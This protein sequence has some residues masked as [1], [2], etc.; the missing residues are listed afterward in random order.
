MEMSNGS[1]EVRS[2]VRAPAS[3]LLA[4]T[5][6]PHV[7]HH[8]ALRR[9]VIACVALTG[10]LG[11]VVPIEADCDGD[12]GPEVVR[13]VELKLRSSDAQEIL[14]GL[15][16]LRGV[17]PVPETVIAR[18]AELL[19]ANSA[20]DTVNSRAICGHVVRIFEA[21]GSLPEESRAQIEQALLNCLSIKRCVVLESAVRVL[22]SLSKRDD[23]LVS[24]IAV[25][26]DDT[27]ELGGRV[28]ALRATGYYYPTSRT[29][30]DCITTA[31]KD[32]DPLIRWTAA[33]VISDRPRPRREDATK[34]LS[35]LLLVAKEDSDESVRA[36]AVD[37][38]GILAAGAEFA[39]T[40]LALL[41]RCDPSTRVRTSAARAIGRLG[42]SERVAIPALLAA[43]RGNALNVAE[44]AMQAIGDYGTRASIVVPDLISLAI[45]RPLLTKSAFVAIGRVG[46]TGTLTDLRVQLERERD[47]GVRRLIEISIDAIERRES[48][49]GR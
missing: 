35:R 44:A 20:V 32:A 36:G 9:W 30:I 47:P 21:G 2:S 48:S 13:R 28:A 14:A 45:N 11:I 12:E 1:E 10:A 29:A 39:V 34:L 8:S 3:S 5:V 37:A 43:V 25:Y 18:L 40:E 27:N 26:D 42:V 24:F 33:S 23:L 4:A 15:L 38:V 49:G 22:S 46:T 41:L 19:Q 6:P 31:L 17:H 16:E 7:W